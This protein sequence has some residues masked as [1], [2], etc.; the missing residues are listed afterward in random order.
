MKKRLLIL[1]LAAAVVIVAGMIFLFS[2]QDGLASSQTSGAVVQLL[3]RWTRPDYASLPQAE[4]NALYQTYQFW[5]RKGAHFSEFALLG[6]FLT[7]LLN[8]LDRPWKAGKSWL[9]GTVYA[10][11]DE[12]HQMVLGTRTAAWQDVAIDSAGV[13]FGVLLILLIL[14]LARRRK[15][16]RR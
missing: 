2:S 1:F 7:L 15:K 6:M 3:L 4:Q 8:A 14:A 12:L 9:L 5:I 11:T 13:L 16:A 10:G